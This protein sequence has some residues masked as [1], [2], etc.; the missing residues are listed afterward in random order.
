MAE[1]EEPLIYVNV[2]RVDTDYGINPD[3]YPSEGEPPSREA[4]HSATVNLVL[5]LSPFAAGDYPYP[6]LD[7]INRKV[8]TIVS[9]FSAIN[10]VAK[11]EH[12]RR[13][14]EKYPNIQFK[15]EDD[16]GWTRE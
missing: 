8:E 1:K 5:T 15:D 16:D 6:E 11:E 7:E 13:L 3:D 4:W 2:V 9:A 12:R 14:R 10:S